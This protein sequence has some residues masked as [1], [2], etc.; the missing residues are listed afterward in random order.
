[1]DSVL[2]LR[3]IPQNAGSP[4]V[5][6][7]RNGGHIDIGFHSNGG[8]VGRIAGIRRAVRVPAGLYFN[9]YITFIETIRGINWFTRSK[10]TNISGNY[11]IAG[12]PDRGTGSA[13]RI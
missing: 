9:C 4:N 1:M 10:A 6:I 2:T 3:A 11:V 13:G 7:G 5:S 8:I 12:P